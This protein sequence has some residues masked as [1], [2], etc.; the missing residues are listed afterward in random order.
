V[1]GLQK[2][3]SSLFLVAVTGFACIS[4]Q[5]TRLERGSVA[6]FDSL[7]QRINELQKQIPKLKQARDVAYY[8]KQRELELTLFVSN[9]EE[10]IH[11]EDL[12]NAKK[13]VE[14]RLEKAE[15]RREQYTVTFCRKYK[16]DVN[17]LIKQQRIYYQA[18]F[19]KK[20]TLKG[21]LTGWRRREERITTKKPSAWLT[22]H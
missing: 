19:A 17:N 16:D 18:L 7:D 10:Y 8:N 9:V 6:F 21:N 12:D 20:K 2:Y 1:S 14:A 3:L 13:I 11:E 22:W 5:T 15:F 4:A